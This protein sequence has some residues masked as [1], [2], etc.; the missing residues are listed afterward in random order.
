MTRLVFAPNWIGD[1]VMAL[2][3]L[4]DVRRH[5]ASGSLVVAARPGVA[6]VMSLAPGIDQ[7][8]RLSG[9]TL[10]GGIRSVA[11]DVAAIRTVR[12]D[13]A[14]LFPNSARTAVL[15]RR[16]A[17][18]ERWGYRTD[19]RR[20]LLTRAIRTPS[21]AVHQVDYYRH[22][23][24]E[25]GFP[26]GAR[27]PRLE[28]PPAAIAKARDLLA[29]SGW[30][31]ARRLVGIGPGAAYGGAKRWPPDRFAA[32]IRTLSHERG[33]L[34][35]VVGSQADRPTVRAI[36]AAL[37][38][39][40]GA[41]PTATIIDLAGQTDIATLCGVLSLT[42]TFVSNDSGAMHLA[43]ALGV[44]VVAMFGPTDDRATSPVGTTRATIVTTQAWCR[45]CMLREC[46]LDHRCM[47]GI[48]AADVIGAVDALDA[49][50]E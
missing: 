43:V 11:G 39:G 50:K 35:V 5:D 32:V 10:L 28:A 14:I 27:A 46:P 41:L 40:S 12:A 8:V 22:L 21:A 4:A 17:I 7:V 47:T 38:A 9:D 45:P 37:R 3:A 20:L 16:A 33:A 25:L 49:V 29:R 19:L 44:P 2:P 26:N 42:S 18:V 15:A 24:T 30:D 34:C 36:D 6:D 48:A 1:A 23:V 31:G 13:A